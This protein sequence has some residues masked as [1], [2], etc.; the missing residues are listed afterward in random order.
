[1]PGE[2]LVFLRDDRLPS[3]EQWQAALDLAETEIVLGTIPDL[4]KHE[5][6]WP[7]T[8]H[9]RAA[10]LEW[11]YGPI[12]ENFG[13]PL[14]AGVGKRTHAIN[15]V[16]HGDIRELLCAM[17]AGAVLAQIADGV[18]FDAHSGG[19]IGA[20]RALHAALDAEEKMGG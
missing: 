10:A 18:V 20:D 15:F 9:R 3:V 14:P 12:E 13:G 1:M 11:Y 7:A 8:H 5:G 16:T 19:V 6:L 4:R 17:I 2:H